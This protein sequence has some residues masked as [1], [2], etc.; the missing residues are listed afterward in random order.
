MEVSNEMKEDIR[1]I[2]SDLRNAIRIHQVRIVIELYLV[3]NING[4]NRE[5]KS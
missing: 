2:Q 4:K 5:D 1:K 3:I